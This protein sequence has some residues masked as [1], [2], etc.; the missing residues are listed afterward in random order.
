[1]QM[2]DGT[3]TYIWEAEAPLHNGAEAQ[4][5]AGFWMGRAAVLKN[6]HPRAYRHP[7]LE[8]RV[9][10]SRMITEISVLKSLHQ[11]GL[12]VPEVL[13]TLR[14]GR[15]LILERIQGTPLCE[16]LEHAE[17][18][19]A[20]NLLNDLGRLLRLLH[21]NDVVHGDLTTHNVV[22]G[23]KGLSLIDFGLA[24]RAPELEHLGL[25]LHVL[26]ESLDARHPGIEDSMRLC[27]EGYL[28]AC[29]GHNPNG[30]SVIRRFESIL[31]RVR[32]HG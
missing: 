14:E 8:R 1:M 27:I 15:I 23:P 20:T 22:L 28:G 7:D 31:S 2:L 5:I 32:Y 21:Q 29:T 3:V 16:A 11:N 24:R 19:V 9:V 30:A 6:R 18:V 13:G 10:R 25:D 4:V 26:K 17:S 12:P